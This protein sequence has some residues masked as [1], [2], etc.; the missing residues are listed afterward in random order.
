ARSIRYSA[1]VLPRKVASIDLGFLG[2]SGDEIYGRLGTSIGLGHGLQL[3][4]NI[5]HWVAGLFGVDVKWAFFENEHIAVSAYAGFLYAHGGWLWLLDELGQTVL[6]DSDLFGMPIGMTVSAPCTRWLQFDLTL[7]YQY[8]KVFGSI[9]PGGSFYA[10]TQY[11]A[12]QVLIWP[13]A[14]VFITAQTAFEFTARLPLY[15]RVPYEVDSTLEVGKGYGNLKDGYAS[16]DFSQGWALE[17]GVRSQLRRWLFAT[18]RLHVGQIAKT[19]YGA[20][21]YPSFNLEFRVP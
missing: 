21:V 20:T 14:R 2:I 12:R 13:T 18:T 7:A 3:D 1:Y 10:E 19:V 8:S 6:S 15:N 17:F 4:A 5:G 16:V 11:G 9:S